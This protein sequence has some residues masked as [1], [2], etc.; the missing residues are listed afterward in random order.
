MLLPREIDPFAKWRNV[1]LPPTRPEIIA[2]QT[3]E[4]ARTAEHGSDQSA[5]APAEHRKKRVDEAASQSMSK[6]AV[7]AQGR[8]RVR[9]ASANPLRQRSARTQ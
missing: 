7:S 5:A 1:P 4:P 3:D 2:T 9:A 6:K 8:P